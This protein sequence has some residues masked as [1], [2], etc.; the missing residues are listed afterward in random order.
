M[1]HRRHRRRSRLPAITL[2]ALVAVA[3]AACSS[4]PAA[5]FDPTGA[6]TADGRAAGAYPDLEARVPT[7]YEGRGPDQ[8]DSGRHCSETNLGTLASAGIDEVRFAGG[9]WDFGG[10]RAAALVV[11]EAPGLT[12]TQVA[13]FYAASA[14]SANR[15]QVTGETTPTI[16]GQPA[17]RLD[18]MTGDRIQTVV[19]WPSAEPDVVN[20]VITNDLPDPKIEAAVAAFEGR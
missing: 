11:F 18:T 5:S 9:A 3:V 16:A 20:V 2:A 7:T 6:C 15:T 10:N 14:R 12:A 19:T 17:H 1:I 13:E 4:G 8:L